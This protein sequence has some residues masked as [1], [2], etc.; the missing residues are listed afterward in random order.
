VAVMPGL[1]VRM[2]SWSN[3]RVQDPKNIEFLGGLYAPGPCFQPTWLR[4]CVVL[5][6]RPG[7]HD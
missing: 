1:Q 6:N 7:F 4:F 2:R 5:S 3:S